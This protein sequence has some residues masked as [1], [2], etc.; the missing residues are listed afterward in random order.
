[1]AFGRTSPR[2]N[3]NPGVAEVVYQPRTVL[4]ARRRPSIS[5]ICVMKVGDRASRPPQS[6]GSHC[7]RSYPRVPSLSPHSGTAAPESAP[8]DDVRTRNWCRQARVRIC[9]TDRSRRI[10][11]ARDALLSRLGE[12]AENPPS[13]PGSRDRCSPGSNSSVVLE[14]NQLPLDDRSF[15]QAALIWLIRAFRRNPCERPRGAFEPG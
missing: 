1:M 5:V 8:A 9:R 14:Q 6:S 4:A 12:G 3:A 13:C 7:P 2:G 11:I 15:L 10:V